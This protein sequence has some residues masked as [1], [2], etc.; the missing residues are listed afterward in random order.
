ML[1]CRISRV[2][3][4]LS[5]CMLLISCRESSDKPRTSGGKEIS[6]PKARYEYERMATELKLAE[7]DDPYLVLDFD[8][9]ILLIKLKG[10]V[11]WSQALAMSGTDSMEVS[12]SLSHLREKEPID[13][14]P[15]VGKHLFAF[16]PR[17]PDSLL[18]IV[19]SALDVKSDLLQRE[20]P[21]RFQLIWDN[22]LILEFQTEIKG[23]PKAPLK[24]IVRHLHCAFQRLWG[25]RL[26]VVK[27]PATDAL[28]LYRVV[29][30]CMPTLIIF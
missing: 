24:N 29:R 15:I 10:A 20:L 16:Q 1:R 3:Y 22:G 5:V 30:P 7:S 6:D 14:Q 8:R 25:Q 13:L 9:R 27:M 2:L 26:F 23:R 19:S 17:I 28:T 4:G 18:T 12:E 21:S 11:V